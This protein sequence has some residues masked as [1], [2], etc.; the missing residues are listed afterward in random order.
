MVDLREMEGKI[1]YFREKML[2]SAHQFGRTDD[3]VLRASEQ[4]DDLLNRYWYAKK[5][6]KKPTA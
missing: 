6:Y 3:R 5:Q 1:E 2:D 4:L